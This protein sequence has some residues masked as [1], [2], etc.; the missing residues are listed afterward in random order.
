[1][2]KRLYWEQKIIK[3]IAYKKQVMKNN[4][5]IQLLA[6]SVFFTQVD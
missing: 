6:L 5:V 3:K 1:M 2:S 4:N